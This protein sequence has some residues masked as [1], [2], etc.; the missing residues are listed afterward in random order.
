MSRHSR[1]PV[2]ASLAMVLFVVALGAQVDAAPRRNPTTHEVHKGQTLGKIAKRYNVTIAAL[3]HANDV[4]RRKPLKLGQTLC[5][6]TRQDDGGQ[7]AR[8]W[9]DERKGKQAGKQAKA[10][11]KPAAQGPKSKGAKTTGSKAKGPKSKSGVRWHRVYKGQHLGMIARRYN[12]TVDAIVAANEISKR[13]PIIPGQQLIIP[14][15]ADQDGSRARKLL[16]AGPPAERVSH[17]ASKKKSWSRYVRRP[18]RRHFVTIV[19]PSGRSWKGTVLTKNGHVRRPA[20]EAFQHVLATGA[21][22][23]HAIDGRLIQLIARVSDTFGGRTIK[24]AS[25]Y[26]LRTITRSS[27]HRFG[28]AVDFVVAGV[29]N[30]AVVDYVKTFSKVGVGYYPNSTFLHMDVRDLW[31]HWIDYAGPGQPPRYAGFWTKHG[32]TQ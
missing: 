32:R 31:T 21:G 25:G 26:R 9:C 15:R 2:I 4:A 13:A 10:K 14:A 12:V 22:E 20:R 1:S 17:K 8:A 30:R 11:A 7:Q 18:K 28:R 23:E 3:C 16:D 19:G 5:I 29:P 6:P 27:R 24:V